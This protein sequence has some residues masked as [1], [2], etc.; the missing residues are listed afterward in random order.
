MGEGGAFLAFC[1]FL[2]PSGSLG[3]AGCDRAQAVPGTSFFSLT[4]PPPL[5]EAR[6]GGRSRLYLDAV[7]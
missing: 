2:L 3:K 1:P 6:G 4:V 5:L 7:M